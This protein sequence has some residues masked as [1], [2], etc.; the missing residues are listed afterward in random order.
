[1][2]PGAGL[3]FGTVPKGQASTP[4]TVTLFNDPADPNSSTINF[5]GNLLQGNFSETDNCVGTSL[6]PGS[7]CMITVIFKSKSVGLNSGTIT[8]GYTVG[9]TQIIYLRGT[10]Q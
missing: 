9:Q 8:I 7:S 2:S 3:D 4:M 6:A 1:M 10:V 5:T